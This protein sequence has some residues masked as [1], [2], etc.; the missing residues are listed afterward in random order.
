MTT[1]RLTRRHSCPERVVQGYTAPLKGIAL[2]LHRQPVQQ[3]PM[4]QTPIQTTPIKLQGARRTICPPNYKEPAQKRNALMKQ[5]RG[6]DKEGLPSNSLY[7]YSF[8]NDSISDITSDDGVSIASNRS[9]NS[10][11]FQFDL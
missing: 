7:R 5:I 8:F 9:N 11:V 3:T 4:Q 2:A 1:P 10:G 6:N